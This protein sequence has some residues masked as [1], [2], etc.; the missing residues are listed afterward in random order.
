MFEVQVQLTLA[1]LN[2][3]RSHLLTAE[4][5]DRSFVALYGAHGAAYEGER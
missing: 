5:A 3:E 1:E 2:D 4:H